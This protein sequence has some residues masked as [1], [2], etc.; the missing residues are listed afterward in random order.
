METTANTID[1]GLGYPLTVIPYRATKRNRDSIVYECSTE[2]GTEIFNSNLA[3]IEL[4]RG[5]SNASGCPPYVF[6]V[7]TGTNWKESTKKTCIW[8]TPRKS[9][10]FGDFKEGIVK[11]MILV[12]VDWDH[13]SNVNVYVFPR[14]VYPRN[15]VHQISMML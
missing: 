4:Y 6:T 8:T 5:H 10:Y 15:S 14:G 2:T 3:R 1:I 9:I 13:F 7:K 12:Q 11:T